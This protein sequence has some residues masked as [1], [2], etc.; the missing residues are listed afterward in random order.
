MVKTKKMLTVKE[1]LE[2]L[3]RFDKIE[4]HLQVGDVLYSTILTEFITK[5]INTYKEPQ[6]KGTPKGKP[7]GFS[8]LKYAATLFMLLKYNQKKIAQMLGISF[9]L[10]RKWN[11]EEPFV[12]QVMAHCQE[13]TSTVVGRI[14]ASTLKPT[15]LN[16]FQLYGICPI[17]F[18]VETAMR[19][20]PVAHL[21]LFLPILYDT[22]H[23]SKRFFETQ[24][25]PTIHEY[26]FAK[27]E[28]WI[29]EAQKRLK[30]KKLQKKDKE[31]INEF[32]Q[33]VSNFLKL[34]RGRI[35]LKRGRAELR[36][37]KRVRH[38]AKFLLSRE[39]KN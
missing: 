6:R 39:R 33:L 29:A 38:E 26:M 19:E 34:E 20:L 5:K 22:G 7:V 32:L 10:L 28:S 8:K 31:T 17:G 16:D 3:E 4:L 37:R 12:K 25:E 21:T 35:E 30:K 11:T 13:L 24:M 9:G 2:S 1:S 14:K 27:F 15:D 18:M 23:V 36:K